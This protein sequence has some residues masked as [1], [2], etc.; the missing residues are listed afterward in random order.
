MQKLMIYVTPSRASVEIENGATRQ[1]AG[2][3]FAAIAAAMHPQDRIV[4]A[5]FCAGVLAALDA[6]APT[7]TGRTK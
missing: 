5:Q 1:T 6:A 4:L 2:R 3:D 7:I